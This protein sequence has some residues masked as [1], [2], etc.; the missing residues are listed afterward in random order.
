MIEKKNEKW[1][2]RILSARTMAGKFRNL[3]SVYHGKTY[4]QNIST[5]WVNNRYPEIAEK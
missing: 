1:R 5:T 2:M 3:N 4:M